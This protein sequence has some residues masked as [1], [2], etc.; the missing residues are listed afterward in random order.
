MPNNCFSVI[1]AGGKG[2]RFWPLSR[3]GRPK[4]Q[5]GAILPRLSLFVG[6]NF[7]LAGGRRLARAD[8]H[9]FSSSR[10][11]HLTNPRTTRGIA[12]SKKE[13]RGNRM[14]RTRRDG[15]GSR[16]S[17]AAACGKTGR[18]GTNGDGR[19]IGAVGINMERG[20]GIIAGD[21]ERRQ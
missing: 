8:H 16:G 2:T 11:V 6:H 3:A 7:L 21:C 1:I 19:T 12:Q 10:I 4:Q 14:D 13:R 18:G 9:D 20:C 5:D 17:P 15:R